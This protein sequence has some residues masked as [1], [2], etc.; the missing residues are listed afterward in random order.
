MEV[1]PTLVP[2]LEKHISRVL[3]SQDFQIAEI[4]GSC[5]WHQL[6][7]KPLSAFSD[8]VVFKI[9]RLRKGTLVTRYL[10]L[11]LVFF[12]SGVL[13]EIYHVAEGLPRPYGANVHFFMTQAVGI[14][15]EDTVQTMYRAIRGVQRGTPPTT[16]TRLVGYIWLALFLSWS[17]PVWI[18]TR[19]R[20][21]TAD[22]SQQWVSFSL[23]GLL[24][25]TLKSS[26]HLFW[27]GPG[28]KGVE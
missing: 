24:N 17:T 10:H 2:F 23:L 22:P 6:F 12:F 27:R 8:I 28:Y 15:L 16:A 1:S 5:F 18:Y 19:L 25:K 21:T 14:M 11:S 4:V 9:L 13:H 3:H 7:R 26:L 20:V